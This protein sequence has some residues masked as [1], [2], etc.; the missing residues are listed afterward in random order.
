MNFHQKQITNKVVCFL[1]CTIGYIFLYGSSEGGIHLKKLL[2]YFLIF[3][4][5][6]T[7]IG[8][9]GA[10]LGLG[11]EEVATNKETTPVIVES[12]ET[13][14]KPTEQTAIKEEP[15]V[16]EVTYYQ[17]QVSPALDKVQKE[18]DRIWN[19]QWLTTFNGVSDG[20]MDVYKAYKNMTF[21]ETNYEVLKDEIEKI[22]GSD[23]SK[24]NKDLLESYKE[25]LIEASDNRALAAWSAAKMFDEGDFKPSKLDEIKSI[26]SAGDAEMMQAII[27]RLSIEDDLGLVEETI[28]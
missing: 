13:V 24:G 26:V 18:Y 2:K 6:L 1:L 7:A 22:D 12:E 23:L 21:V 11:E 27:N 25:K 20:S 17:N 19:E 5:V 10:A 4:V 8:V 16:D 9:V 15:S 3:V 28:E 14:E